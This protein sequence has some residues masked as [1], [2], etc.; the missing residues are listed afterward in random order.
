MATL[1]GFIL[2]PAT[3]RSTAI[4]RERIVGFPWQYSTVLYCWQLHVGQQRYKGNVLLRFHGS[5]QRFYIVDSYIWVNSDT[6]GTYCCFSMAAFNG[7]IL[8]TTTFGSIA[9]QRE[10]VVAFPWQH[11]AVLYCCQLHVRQQRYKGNVLLR[12]HGH[13]QQFYLVASYT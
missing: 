8:L 12:F 2:L 5:I 6:K 11:S 1:N 13:I 7:F 4:Q 3:C 9:I 10:R